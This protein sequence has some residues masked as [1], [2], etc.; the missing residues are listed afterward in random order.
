M[1][2]L[3]IGLFIFTYFIIPCSSVPCSSVLNPFAP[4]LKL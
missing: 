4:T 2:Y 1:V 3:F